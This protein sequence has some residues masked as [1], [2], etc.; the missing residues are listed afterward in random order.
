MKMKNLLLLATFLLCTMG[1]E[2]QTKV[3]AH[4]GFWKTTG[5]AQNSITS[6]TKADSIHCFGSEIDLW[7]TSDGKVMVNHDP[8]FNGVTLETSPYNEVKG[9]KL[10]NGEYMPTFDKY[11]KTA[12][13]LG[14]QLIVEIK[15]HKDLARQNLCIDKALKMVKKAKMQDRV[16]Y[17][18]FS[19]DAC[20]KL[21]AD[22]PANTEVYYLNGDLAPQEIKNLGFAGIDYDKKVLKDHPEWIEQ[23]HNLGLK[24]NVWTVNKMEDLRTFVDQKVDYITTNEPVMLQELLAQESK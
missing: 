20:K 9:L 24:V 23:C 16:T 4:R 11:L 7:V 19:L 17:I 15:T 8:V 2:A 10:A 3:I 5:S 18:A 13:K 22:A 6:I 1:I 21:K 12:K 14:V